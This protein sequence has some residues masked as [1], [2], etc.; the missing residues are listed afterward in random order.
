MQCKQFFNDN[1]V[2][3]L[4]DKISELLQC[5]FNDIF[6][7][8]SE[9]AAEPECLLCYRS[10]M[11]E[12]F[13]CHNKCVGEKIWQCWGQSVVLMTCRALQVWLTQFTMWKWREVDTDLYKQAHALCETCVMTDVDMDLS[14]LYVNTQPLF[15]PPV[16]SFGVSILLKL[17]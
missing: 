3:M 7:C 8:L 13:S 11:A 10:F 12:S 9:S 17:H 1:S 6:L 4:H 5:V 16:G 14:W 2:L 15:L